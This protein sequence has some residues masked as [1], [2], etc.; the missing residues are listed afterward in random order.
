MT[1]QIGIVM[2]SDSDLETMKQAA[3]VCEEFEVGYEIR[4]LSAHRTPHDATE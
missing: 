4:V 3:K 1:P 2:G